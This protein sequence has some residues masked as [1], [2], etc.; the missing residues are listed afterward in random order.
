MSPARCSSLILGSALL[1]CLGCGDTAPTATNSPSPQ[2]T[3]GPTP[4]MTGFIWGQVIDSTGLC[5]RGAI[6]EIVNGLA[7]G[8]SSR[9]P[10]EC[11]AWSYVGYEFRNLPIGATE[12]LRAMAPGYQ[13]QEQ[14]VV[15]GN[16][17]YPVQFVLVPE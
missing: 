8:H 4:S 15:A 13:S 10:D 2:S 7:T 5:I 17:G 11:D 14:Q 3:P 12:T 6:V 16:G 9:Q 1:L